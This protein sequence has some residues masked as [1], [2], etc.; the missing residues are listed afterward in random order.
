MAKNSLGI[1]ALHTNIQNRGKNVIFYK[2]KYLTTAH[3]NLILKEHR[4]MK[5]C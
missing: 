3:I 5:F 4:R 1:R 2:K